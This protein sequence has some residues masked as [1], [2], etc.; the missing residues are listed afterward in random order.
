MGGKKTEKIFVT[1][2]VFKR[3]KLTTILIK[4]PTE[5][6]WRRWKGSSRIRLPELL[7]YLHMKAAKSSALRTDR[8][9]LPEQ[10]PGTQL[11]QADST[12]QGHNATGRITSMTTSRFEPAS[13]RLVVLCLNQQCRRVPIDRKITLTGT[14]KKYDGSV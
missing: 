3:A 8:L 11:L 2:L 1:E 10:I 4:L 7:E 6:L 9:Y 14:F 13:F 12:P 5:E